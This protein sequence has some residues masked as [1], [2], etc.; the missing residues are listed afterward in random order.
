MWWET[1]SM[2]RETG[3]ASGTGGRGYNYDGR[4]FASAGW[5]LLG[6]VRG[7]FSEAL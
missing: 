5:V 3:D 6:L 7:A 4:R 2:E 1:V